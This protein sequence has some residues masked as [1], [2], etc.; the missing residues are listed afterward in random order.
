MSGV[1]QSGS[2]YGK[3]YYGAGPYGRATSILG[4]GAA[5]KGTLRPQLIGQARLNI[6]SAPALAFGLTQMWAPITVEPCQPWNAIGT[7]GCWQAVPNSA[8]SMFP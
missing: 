2:A 7:P 4:I 5:T 8:G 6:V 1:I 3:G